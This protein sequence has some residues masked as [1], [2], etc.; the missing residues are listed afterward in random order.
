MNKL[1]CQTDTKFSF[2]IYGQF[3]GNEDPMPNA[4]W[5]VIELGRN[6]MCFS[7]VTKFH[8]D[9]KNKNKKQYELEMKM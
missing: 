4:I 8:E 3:N 7:I 5:L 1:E 6:N 9:P 2:Q